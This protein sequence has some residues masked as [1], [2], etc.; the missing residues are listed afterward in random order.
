ML[1]STMACPPGPL[2]ATVL[3]LAEA[4]GQENGLYLLWGVN[5]LVVAFGTFFLFRRLLRGVPRDLEDAARIDGCGFWRTY[6]H[7]RLPLARPALALT[8][9]LIL[10]AVCD[11]ALAPLAET[12]GAFSPALMMGLMM[13]GFLLLVPPIMTIFCTGRSPR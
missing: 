11:D 7:A 10:I 3:G 13:A 1:I 4:P 9:V 5:T 6:W 12:G 8:G 2:A